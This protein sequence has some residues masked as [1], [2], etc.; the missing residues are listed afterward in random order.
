MCPLFSY[1]GGK[2]VVEQLYISP[3]PWNSAPV[4]LQIFKVIPE[5]RNP[6]QGLSAPPWSF[7]PD[8]LRVCISVTVAAFLSQPL[9]PRVFERLFHL[10]SCSKVAARAADQRRTPPGQRGPSSSS[11]CFP[12]LLALQ[13]ELSLFKRLP[14]NGSRWCRIHQ[15]AFLLLCVRNM[16]QNAKRQ[17]Y[18][19]P[20]WHSHC[21]PLWIS[22]QKNPF[23]SNWVWMK[24]L[25]LPIVYSTV[26]YSGH[27]LNKPRERAE[28]D[29]EK[30]FVCVPGLRRI[31]VD[32]ARVENYVR[33]SIK[34]RGV[35]VACR[36]WGKT[37]K[38]FGPYQEQGGTGMGFSENRDNLE[39]VASGIQ[40][41]QAHWFNRNC[42]LRSRFFIWRTGDWLKDLVGLIALHHLPK[43]K[44]LPGMWQFPTGSLTSRCVQASCMRVRVCV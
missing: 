8:C 27:W 4:M 1:A 37:K 43:L 35:I 19:V 28:T 18:L 2:K 31:R 13:L 17:G 29:R 10:R 41:G 22:G 32:L 15:I 16:G 20:L 39:K 7:K 12:S 25:R 30:L 40:S 36:K 11:R 9:S 6:S 33:K 21:A 14:A 44:N 38:L 3:P 5:F 26:L 42:Q 34:E 23:H 24:H